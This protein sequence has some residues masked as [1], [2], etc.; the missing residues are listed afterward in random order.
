M[1]LVKVRI[2]EDIRGKTSFLVQ[3]CSYHLAKETTMDSKYQDEKEIR[4]VRQSTL[5]KDLEEEVANLRKIVAQKR[6]QKKS[7]Q[8]KSRSISKEQKQS[9]SKPNFESRLYSH[10]NNDQ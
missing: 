9:P 2:Q 5:R 1:F 3:T 10:R 4:Q 6:I 7:K 8:R